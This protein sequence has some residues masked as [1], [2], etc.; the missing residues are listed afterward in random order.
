MLKVV[1]LFV[2]ALF[3]SAVNAQLPIPSKPP[4]FTYG[5]GRADAGVQLE[6]YVDLVRCT[7]STVKMF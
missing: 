3:G 6:T 7:A 2:F 4:G 1:K 5:R